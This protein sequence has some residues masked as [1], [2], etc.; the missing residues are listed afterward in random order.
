MGSKKPKTQTAPSKPM[1]RVVAVHRN[2]TDRLDEW[3]GDFKWS[4]VAARFEAILVSLEAGDVGK[5]QL[6]MK[7]MLRYPPIRNGGGVLEYGKVQRGGAPRV[8]VL[9]KFDSFFFVAAGLEEGN[10]GCPEIEVA[11]IRGT[12]L[13]KLEPQPSVEAYQKA[14]GRDY[15]VWPVPALGTRETR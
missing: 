12:Q 3:S 5:A 15:D 13:S 11:R 1:L 10:T 8:F 2:V 14:L 6:L 9:N 7:A 4:T